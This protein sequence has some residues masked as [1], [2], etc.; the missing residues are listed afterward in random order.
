MNQQ[1][2][3]PPTKSRRKTG[4]QPVQA[5]DSLQHGDRVS[6]W[7]LDSFLYTA[8]VDDRTDDGR[9]VWV[10]ENGPGGRRLIFRDDPV[11]LFSN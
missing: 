1:A 5:W 11:I 10:I 7:S 9:L 8:C 6:V 3:T 2:L 4:H